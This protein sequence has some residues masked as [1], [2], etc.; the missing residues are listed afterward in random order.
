MKRPDRGR[1]AEQTARMFARL[2]CEIA[3]M[4]PR[5][6]GGFTPAMDHVDF[7]GRLLVRTTREYEDGTADSTAG[8]RAAEQLRKARRE[9]VEI[10]RETH[11]PEQAA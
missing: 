11:T 4:W 3:A 2:E 9:A 10:Y 1:R 6:I 8:V 5:G 7:A